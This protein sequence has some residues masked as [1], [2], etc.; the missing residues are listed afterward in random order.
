MRREVPEVYSER[1]EEACEALYR[2][3]R[4]TTYEAITEETR[5]LKEQSLLRLGLS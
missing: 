3:T 2:L 1:L 4:D 5:R